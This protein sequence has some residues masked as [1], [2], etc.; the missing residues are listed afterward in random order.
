MSVFVIAIYIIIFYIRSWLLEEEL[1]KMEKVRYRAIHGKMLISVCEL[2]TLLLSIG[3]YAFIIV[4]TVP[5]K[6]CGVFRYSSD[7]NEPWTDMV[8]RLNAD[9]QWGWLGTIIE[10]VLNPWFIYTINI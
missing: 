6:M 5:N 2:V 10:L 7:Y 4:S 1:I 8:A 3:W 9:S